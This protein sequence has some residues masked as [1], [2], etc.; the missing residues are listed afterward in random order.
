M[1]VFD[2]DTTAANN[3]DSDGNINF[4]EG[5]APSTVNDSA[6]ALMARVAHW[7]NMLGSNVTQGGASNA[8]TLTSGESLSAYSA[9]MRLLW[10]PNADSTGAVTL[11]VDAIGAKKVYMPDGTQAGS[12]ELDSDSLYDVVYDA[13]L[14]TSSGGFKIVGFPDT[15]LTAGDYLTVSNN[16]SDI[17]S[18]STAR[19]NLGAYGSGSDVSFGTV[20]AS[21]DVAIDTDTLFVDVSSATVSIGGTSG[22]GILDI[23]APSASGIPPLLVN[24]PGNATFGVVAQLKT[25]AG[26]DNPVFSIENYNGGS[27]VRYGISVNDSETLEFKSGAYT[28]AFGTSRFA[29]SNTGTL[30]VP[31]VYNTTTSGAANVNVDTSGLLRRST[32]AEKYKI[33]RENIAPE[34]IDRFFDICAQNDTLIWYRSNPAMTD[35]PREHSYYG[36]IADRF[37]EDFPQLCHFGS[38]FEET[39]DPKTGEVTKKPIPVE[40]EG[41]AYE[42]T[43]PFLIARILE[44]TARIEALEGANQ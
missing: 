41:F 17:A 14:D 4:A 21:G 12:G 16:L 35:D 18:A 26:S 19:G 42:R 40:V 10:Q 31:G 32:S 6:R 36:M 5:Q 44:L 29:L 8:Y 11:N 27:P 9:G 22:G 24:H 37:V 25:T 1:S 7:L 13:S 20:T 39:T 34:R 38:E 23:T 3:G 33:K 28:G 2:W 15:T 30:T 43:A